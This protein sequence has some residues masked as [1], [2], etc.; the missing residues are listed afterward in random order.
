MDRRQSSVGAFFDLIVD[1][2]PC[3]EPY[4]VAN[5]AKATPSTRRMQ[6]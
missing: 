3:Q 2:R 1:E 5:L 4:R 6:R